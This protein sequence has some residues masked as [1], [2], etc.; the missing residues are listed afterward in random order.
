VFILANHGGGQRYVI[1]AKAAD[2]STIRLLLVD[3]KEESLTVYTDGFRTYDML[4]EDDE[5][6][7]EYVVHGDSKYTDGE[8]HVNT[9]ESHC[10]VSDARLS[11]HRSISKDKLA[12]YLRALQLHRELYQKPKTRGTQTRC[13]SNSLKSTMCYARA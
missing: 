2:E 12:E 11:P 10:R 4:K 7:R 3:R 13:P 8:V 5:F 6:D 1:P 9:R